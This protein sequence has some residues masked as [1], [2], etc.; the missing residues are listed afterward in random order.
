VSWN[1][2]RWAFVLTVAFGGALFWIAP[3]PPMGD[4]PQHAAQVV[5]LHDLLTGSS[6]WSDLVQIN[7]LTPYLFGY[8]L[9]TLLTFAMPVLV[10]LKVVITG[11]YFAFVRAGVSLR[12]ELDGDARLD[13]LFIPGFF[14]LAFQYG[15]FPFLVAAPIGL[16]V[17]RL[18]RKF[19]DAPTNANAARM[20]VAGVVLFFCHGLVFFFC[21]GVG[22]VMAVARLKRAN[23]IRVLIPYTILGL[24]ITAQFIHA[25]MTE[26]LLAHGEAPVNWEWDKPGGW[27]RILAFPNCVVASN[28]RDPIFLPIVI[29]ML[30]APWL[31]GARLATD[32]TKLAP[33]AAMIFTWLV[34]PAEIA[35]TNLLYARF[36][37][38]LLPFYALAFRPAKDV[39]RRAAIVEAALPLL[40]CIFFGG[41]GLRERKFA[42]EAA[43]FETVLAA[44]EPN[45]R[46]L[47][48][49][50]DPVSPA[51][52]HP[53]A[54]HAY[55]SW[56]Q[57]E[58][59]GFVDFNFA[60]LLPEVVRFKPGKAPPPRADVETFDWHAVDA[61]LYRYYF[62]H[63][64]SPISV[65]MFDNDQCTVSVVKEDGD[66]SLFEKKECHK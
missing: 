46:A 44:A 19:A 8:A 66:F 51:I 16:L 45:E 33:A 24:V 14:G 35:R 3:R 13:W 10:A 49:V 48:V 4:L 26:P 31:L 63:H 32:R 40:C 7:Y 15:L 20:V 27:H 55:A 17:L 47:S 5:M 18:A 34:V 29:A 36:A 2:R 59:G 50:L 58:R 52:R 64:T 25:R 42:R 23:V 60:Y 6:R 57:A 1:L 11:A 21:V 12:R 54:Y 37:I 9:A 43:S 53:W 65:H 22:F 30:V 41:L 56:Y 28:L 39:G 61:S 62:V 38:F